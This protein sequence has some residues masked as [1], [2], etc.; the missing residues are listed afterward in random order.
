MSRL[1]ST[2]KRSQS[3][4]KKARPLRWKPKG[5][6]LV[7]DGILGASTPQT[8]HNAACSVVFQTCERPD[9]GAIGPLDLGTGADP[10]GKTGLASK[11]LKFKIGSKRKAR[12]L[13]RALRR[14][15]TAEH[16][17]GENGHRS[18][19]R[20]I[21]KGRSVRRPSIVRKGGDAC[22]RSSLAYATRT[23]A[24]RSF[25]HRAE[26]GAAHSV[27]TLPPARPDRC[28]PAG[29]RMKAG[30][31]LFPARLARSCDAA[32]IPSPLPKRQERS[33]SW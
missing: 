31:S 20:P 33:G 17:I 9:W 10:W 15:A 21:S 5:P 16:P 7:R 27:S 4:N 8:A 28:R 26:H 24:R 32:R 19:H 30:S 29:G 18:D 13:V 25:R 23:M 2:P 1:S 22:G 3:D 11:T 12:R 14:G 6:S